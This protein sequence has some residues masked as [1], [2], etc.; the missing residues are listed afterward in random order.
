MGSKW[1]SADGGHQPG[2][3][4]PQRFHRENV[5]AGA[6]HFFDLVPV[7]AVHPGPW[8]YYRRP[9]L[10]AGLKISGVVVAALMVAALIVDQLREDTLM[11]GQLIAAGFAFAFL[12]WI[13]LAGPG[14]IVVKGR[15]RYRP[16]GRKLAEESVKYLGSA[17]RGAAVYEALTSAGTTRQEIQEWSHPHGSDASARGDMYVAVYWSDRDDVAFAAVHLERE[18]DEVLIWPPVQI[19][20]DWV[21]GLMP[22]YEEPGPYVSY[23]SQS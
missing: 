4:E 12:A 21:A 8:S 7:L 17:D 14:D 16:S 11:E 18:D 19:P 13:L 9:R 23:P 15:L 3:S 22:R 20:R 1:E 10:G 6:Q 2:A 5:P